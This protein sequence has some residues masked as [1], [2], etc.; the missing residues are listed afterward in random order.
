MKFDMR[1]SIALQNKASTQNELGNRVE[2]YID[3]ATFRAAYVPNTGRMYLGGSSVHTETDCEF[4]IRYS[5]IPKND[6]YVLFENTRYYIQAVIDYGGLH[7]ELKIICKL[8][9]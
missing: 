1:H 7:R 8:E 5:P 3:V 4:Q 9:K 6:M 2:S